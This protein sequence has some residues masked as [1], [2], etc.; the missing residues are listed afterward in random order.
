[1]E[2]EGKYLSLIFLMGSICVV[3]TSAIHLDFELDPRTT[4]PPGNKE[5]GLPYYDVF[6]GKYVDP[7]DD[8]LRDQ[9]NSSSDSSQD[10]NRNNDPDRS[11][12]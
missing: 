11:N 5:N 6:E 3:C 9:R 10:V 1:M 2:K 8:I 7:G 12:D 4:Y